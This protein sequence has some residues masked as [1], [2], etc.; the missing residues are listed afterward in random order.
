[1]PSQILVLLTI[2]LYVQNAKP[3]KSNTI[4]SHE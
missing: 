4:I 2:D 3:F 1:M